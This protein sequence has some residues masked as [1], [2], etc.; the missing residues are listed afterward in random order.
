MTTAQLRTIGLQVVV[1]KALV[2]EMKADAL[3][4]E[5]PHFEILKGP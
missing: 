5:A 4:A 1:V 2:A 3:A